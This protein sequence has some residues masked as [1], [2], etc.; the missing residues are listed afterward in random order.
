[1]WRFCL[2]CPLGCPVSDCYV[3]CHCLNSKPLLVDWHNGSHSDR[4]AF[5]TL[6]V[7][8]TSISSIILRSSSI[9]TVSGF[10]WQ[11][12]NQHRGT[13]LYWKSACAFIYVTGG[14]RHGHTLF[15]RRRLATEQMR[16]VDISETGAS[17]RHSLCALIFDRRDSATGGVRVG[18]CGRITS[19]VIWVCYS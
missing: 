7:S 14:L 12:D 5:E 2:L 4:Q 16:W 18:K 1:M 19:W 11:L 17:R 13:S 10:L 3:R 15:D 8:K 9:F 6:L